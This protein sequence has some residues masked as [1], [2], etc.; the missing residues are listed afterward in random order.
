MKR[1]LS[2]VVNLEVDSLLSRTA[3]AKLLGR[4]EK[5]LRQWVTL[6]TGPRFLKFGTSQQSRTCYRRSDLEAWVLTA[7][8]VVGGD[9]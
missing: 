2:A 7:S 9:A 8:H 1:N 5:T 3:A 6:G 4:S